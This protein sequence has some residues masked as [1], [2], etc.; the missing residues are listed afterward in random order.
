[1]NTTTTP[2]VLLCYLRTQTAFDEGIE[3][4]LVWSGPAGR[5]PNQGEY[6]SVH[7]PDDKGERTYRVYS[8]STFLKPD[9]GALY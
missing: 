3:N 2:C 6:V 7:L 9:G 1:M 5:V 8:V 4:P